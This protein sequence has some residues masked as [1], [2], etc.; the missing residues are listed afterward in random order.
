M[1]AAARRRGM[2]ALVELHDE[3]DLQKCRPLVPELVGIN[4]RDLRTFRVDLLD[5]VLLRPRVGW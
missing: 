2:N 5:P 4:C 3:A 1:H